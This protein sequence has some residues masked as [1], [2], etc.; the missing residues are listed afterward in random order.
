VA[1]CNR[2]QVVYVGTLDYAG[3]IVVIE[4]GYGLKTWYYNLGTIAVAVGDTVERG[5]LIGTAG[6]SGFIGF[7]GVHI[8]MSVGNQF[9]CPYDTWADSEIAGKVIIARIEE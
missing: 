6:M 7:N 2:G 1:A 3:N 4:H 8:A 5:Q 9:V